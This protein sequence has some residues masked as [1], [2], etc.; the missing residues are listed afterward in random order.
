MSKRWTA[1]RV[2]RTVDRYKQTRSAEQQEFDRRKWC[3][4]Y[5]AVPEIVKEYGVS[6]DAAAKIS[7]DRITQYMTESNIT[8]AAQLPPY[9]I[10]PEEAE[11]FA[12]FL[13]NDFPEPPQL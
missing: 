5:R 12:Q 2:K 7:R 1:A 6:F 10:A 11:S 13:L 8:T 9:D 3:F 4:A